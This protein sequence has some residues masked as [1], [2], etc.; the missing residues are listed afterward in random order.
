[1]LS[2]LYDG[3]TS[4]LYDGLTSWLYD[5]LTSW[6]YDG[7]TCS[8]GTYMFLY[9]SVS[10]SDET[11]HA[12]GSEGRSINVSTEYLISS[13]NSIWSFLSTEVLCTMLREESGRHAQVNR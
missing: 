5:G 13:T 11:Y 1:M 3:L 2:W 10:S 8:A 7:L 12:G 4:W 6:L 9:V